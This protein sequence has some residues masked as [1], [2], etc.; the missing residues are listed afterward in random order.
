MVASGLL[1]N[2]EGGA[3][4]EPCLAIHGGAG[5]FDRGRMSA[6]RQTACRDV[7]SESLEGGLRRL[8]Q[9]GSALD[10][11]QAAVCVLEDS[12]LFNAGHGSRLTSA[13]TVEMDAAIMDGCETRAG[14]VAAICRVRNPIV[15]ARAVLDAGAHVLLCGEGADAFAREAGIEPV[16]PAALV[17]AA[18]RRRGGVVSGKGTVGAVARD[19][20]G[21]L[22]AATSTGGT[23]D[24][25]PGRVGDSPLIGA[26]TWADDLS[27]AVSG[28]GDG[29]V[30]I[31]T[32]F[33][34]EVDARVRH[35]Q[36][37]LEPACLAVLARV[38]ALG[39]EGGCVALA[40]AGPP[41]FARNASGMPRGFIEPG[42]PARVAIFANE[43]PRP[44]AG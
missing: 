13:G 30:F 20:V 33:A 1:A 35:R 38:R 43:S 4:A 12:E 17:A 5:A 19:A 6:E 10:A 25:H 2:G 16:D 42:Q 24:K 8:A 11:V 21:H 44:R 15:A 27:C 7:L 41:I 26:G 31:R 39:G 9:G 40:R 3:I 32:V 14:A 23:Q 28:T 29:E 22:A 37:Q 36:Q 18:R 34:H